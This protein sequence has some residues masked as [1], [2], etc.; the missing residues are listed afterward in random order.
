M[1]PPV[2]DSN[3]QSAPVAGP[4]RT[5]TERLDWLTNSEHTLRTFGGR[6]WIARH[7]LL[8]NSP[9]AAIDAAMYAEAAIVKV[10]KTFA[11]AD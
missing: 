3:E 6:W 2:K 5:D 9:R 7:G 10:A 8:R 1:L 4:D 11:T